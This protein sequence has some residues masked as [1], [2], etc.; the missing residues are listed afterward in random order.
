MHSLFWML[1]TYNAATKSGIVS[2]TSRVTKFRTSA[3]AGATRY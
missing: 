2:V 3:P 1:T